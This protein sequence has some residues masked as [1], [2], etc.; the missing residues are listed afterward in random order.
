[1]TKVS[2]HARGSG[3]TRAIAALA[4]SSVSLALA[5]CVDDITAASISNPA[6]HH[7][8]GYGASPEMLMVEVPHF[9]QGLSRNQVADVIRFIERYKAESTG[10]LRIEAPKGTNLAVSRSL[11]QVEELLEN[12]GV[13]HTAIHLARLSGKSGHAAAIGMSY[14]R[15]V[16]VPPD[17]GD[18]SDDLGKNRER[19][20]YNNFGCA[21]QRNLALTVAN[22]RD[23]QHPQPETPRS[24]ERRSA[25]W[26]E[27]VGAASTPGNGADAV[28]KAPATTTN[29]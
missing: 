28:A 27:Y 10:S 25:T 6:T 13:P 16:A 9:A 24:S 4:L 19:L 29:K 12:A 23:L 5:G 17:C 11:R 3:V 2:K 21:T 18:W 8:I 20:P 1:M 7:P 14:D 15:T 22:G 26:S